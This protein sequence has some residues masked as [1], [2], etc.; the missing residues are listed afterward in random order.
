MQIKAKVNADVSLTTIMCVRCAIILAIYGGWRRS[1]PAGN[2]WSL[3][4]E[5]RP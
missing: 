5:I 3:V 4:L 2:S 1:W